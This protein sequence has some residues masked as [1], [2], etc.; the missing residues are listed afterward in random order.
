MKDSPETYREKIKGKK[1]NPAAAYEL[2]LTS[3]REYR[4]GDQISYYV[5]GARR[6][7]AVH[8][9]SKLASEWRGEKRDENVAYYLAKL[10]GLY[11][12]FSTGDVQKE[13]NLG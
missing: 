3:E 2:A 11:K 13:L 9:N 4:A 1:R 5:T 12:K 8:E 7:V 10:D 6:S